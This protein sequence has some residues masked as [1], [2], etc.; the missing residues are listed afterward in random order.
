MTVNEAIAAAKKHCEANPSKGYLS[1]ALTYINAIPETMEL[2][3]VEGLKTQ[4]IY[5]LG[6]LQAWRGEEARTVKK[7]LNDYAKS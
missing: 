2:Y 4:I 6:N 3:G 1:Y 7:L 5:I